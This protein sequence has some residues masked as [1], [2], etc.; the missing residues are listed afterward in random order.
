MFRMFRI[1]L[2]V[3]LSHI[4]LIYAQEVIYW[5]GKPIPVCLLP[6]QGALVQFDYPFALHIK[7]STLKHIEIVN[8]QGRL[9]LNAQQTLPKK[10]LK[11]QLEDSKHTV[12]LLH[13]QADTTCKSEDI[14][15]RLKQGL[16]Q[17]HIEGEIKRFKLYWTG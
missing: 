16:D 2:C 12:V 14:T 4:S 10:M 8:N 15:V 11:V 9:Y 13:V 7:E 1:C 17:I 5:N 6:K 3:F